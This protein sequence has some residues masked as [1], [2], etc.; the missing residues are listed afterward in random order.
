MHWLRGH[1]ESTGFGCV[2]RK[3][4]QPLDDVKHPQKVSNSGLLRRFQGIHL[5]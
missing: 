3:S 5:E 1:L 4:G 2:A